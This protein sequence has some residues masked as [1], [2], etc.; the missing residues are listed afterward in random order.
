MTAG[1]VRCRAAACGEAGLATSHCRAYLAAVI[2]WLSGG[3][4][5]QAYLCQQAGSPLFCRP[6]AN[7]LDVAVMR[8]YYAHSLPHHLKEESIPRNL[9]HP[10]CMRLHPVSHAEIRAVRR[11]G[12]SAPP[13]HVLLQDSMGV[14]TF[15]SSDEAFAAEDL[16]NA[17][18]SGDAAQIKQ[19]ITPNRCG[20]R[21]KVLLQQGTF[22]IVSLAA[23]Y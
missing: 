21:G 6:H 19:L 9:E 13:G 14:P 10:L 2:I 4:A 17:Y 7:V 5:R 23:V 18:R 12:N 11:P 20:R 8:E 3:D 1:M 22:P 16:L 15:S